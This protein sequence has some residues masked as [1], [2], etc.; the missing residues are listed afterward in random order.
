MNSHAARD[1]LFA[2]FPTALRVHACHA[3]SV[4]ILP[5]DATLLASNDADP[6]HA[7]SIGDAAWGVQFHPEFD[8]GIMDFY[9]NEFA[10]M[11]RTGGFDPDRLR[12]LTEN[13]QYGADLLRRFGEIINESD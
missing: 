9:L 3:Q 7:F 2:G 8:A 11:L 1:R 6:H 5:P 10:D 13:T 12:G 4:L